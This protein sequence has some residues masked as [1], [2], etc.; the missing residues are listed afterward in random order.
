MK[1]FLFKEYTHIRLEEGLKSNLTA[2]HF[3]ETSN[4]HFNWLLDELEEKRLNKIEH[5]GHFKKCLTNL[6]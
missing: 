5:C 1:L 2:I 4:F 6:V 3:N